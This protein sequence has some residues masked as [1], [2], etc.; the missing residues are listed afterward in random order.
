MTSILSTLGLFFSV[1]A[2]G[3]ILIRL[4]R[5]PLVKY[6]PIYFILVLL[7][8]IVLYL[9]KTP[10]NFW[11]VPTYGLIGF[12]IV[13]IA[14][15]LFGKKISFNNYESCLVAI[16]L[17]PWYLGMTASLIYAFILLIFLTIQSYVALGR[18][19]KAVGVGRMSM[20]TA[21]KKLNDKEKE[22]LAEKGSTIFVIPF[23][24]SAVLTGTI[25]SI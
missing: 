1:M 2:I 16:G 10:Y 24:I 18:G 13:F 5:L 19:F 11:L 25:I 8:T 4:V 21:R 12:I 15:A 3:L 23:L 9:S 7:Q 6:L 17:F 22:I 14:A 20:L